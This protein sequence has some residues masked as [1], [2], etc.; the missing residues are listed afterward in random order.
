MHL[1]SIL[2][3]RRLLPDFLIRWGI[4]NQLKQ[5]SLLLSQNPKPDESWIEQLSK[6]PI[7]ECTET[8][9]EQHYEIPTDYFKTVLGKHLKY[10]SCY[11]DESTTTL[12]MAEVNMLSLSCEHAHLENGQN[13]LE[14][15]CGWGSFS[16]WM[17]E[18]YP[19]STITAMSHS[20][21]Q[22]AYIDSEI[23][24]RGLSNLKVITSDINNFDTSERFD[25][26]VSIEMFEHLRNHSL[27]FEGLNTW[28]KDDGLIFIHIFAHHK[29][30]YLF[31]VEHDRD[32]M[33]EYFFTGGMMPSINL[34]PK[35]AKGFKELNRWE[36]NGTH[37]SK[38]L[39]AWLSKQDE[40]ESIIMNYFMDTYGKDAKLWIQRWRI[41]YLACSEL[42]AY[43]KGKEWPVMHYLFAK[44]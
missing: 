1:P 5:H 11:W 43:N 35:T 26:I 39:E 42:F 20:K 16:L 24:R 2:A 4:R 9:K 37:Y 36:I 40:N 23:E 44:K 14:L 6:G 32:W 29:E 28:L 22:K 8:S 19:E 34:L 31:E 13:I 21:T 41:F 17:A 12:K 27:L 7:A 3:E 25:R 33:A 18:H 30:S 15:G 38:T 10:S